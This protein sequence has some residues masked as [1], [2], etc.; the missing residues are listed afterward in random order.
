VVTAAGQ[1]GLM[2]RVDGQPIGLDAWSPD[3]PLNAVVVTPAAFRGLSP[4]Q[5]TRVIDLL[6]GATLDGGVHLVETLAAGESA[7]TVEEL[8][9]RYRGWDGPESRVV[10]PQSA[11][12]N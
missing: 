3:A 10:T 1:A 7:V 9:A 2:S 8:R 6:K 5:R 11:V 4:E 12:A